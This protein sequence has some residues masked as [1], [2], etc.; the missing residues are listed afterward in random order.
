MVTVGCSLDTCAV[1]A[2]DSAIGD[3]EVIVTHLWYCAHK[4]ST[5]IDYIR[6]QRVQHVDLGSCNDAADPI[7]TVLAS[8]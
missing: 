4:S 8:C 5:S 1:F 2:G 6:V 3:H 7:V